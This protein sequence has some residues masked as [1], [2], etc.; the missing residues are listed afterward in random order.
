MG[1]E[2]THEFI[3]SIPDSEEADLIKPQAHWNAK[4]KIKN[5]L[6]YEL[7]EEKDLPAGTTTYTFDELDGDTDLEYK[8]EYDLDVIG[9]GFGGIVIK[10]NNITDD[11]GGTGFYVY[12]GGH[13]EDNTFTLLPLGWYF[14]SEDHS[15]YGELQIFAKTG[16]YRRFRGAANVPINANNHYGFYQLLHWWKNTADNITNIV[17]ACRTGGSFSG[18][19]KLWKKI[20]TI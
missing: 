17:V 7:V 6:G 8:F 20:P 5:L 15:E 16:R 18:N 14:Y 4:H 12:N 9:S 10:P 2:I 13:G 3:S 19:I 11:Q 1:A